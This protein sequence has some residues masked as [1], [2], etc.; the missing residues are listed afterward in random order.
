M[1]GASKRGGEREGGT[2]GAT[3]ARRGGA[4]L[5]APHECHERTR[6][7][8]EDLGMT[9]NVCRTEL[10]APQLRTTTNYLLGLQG[11]S[12]PPARPPSHASSAYP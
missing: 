8:E 7:H 5:N 2:G 10:A 4:T 3:G 12:T 1:V 6:R 9:L 11:Y